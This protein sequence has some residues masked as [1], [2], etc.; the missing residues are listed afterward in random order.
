M[1]FWHWFIW[2]SKV[3]SWGT[4]VLWNPLYPKTD[5]LQKLSCRA[6]NENLFLSPNQKMLRFIYP[7]WSCLHVCSCITHYSYSFVNNSHSQNSQ[8]S[9]GSKIPTFWLVESK[10]GQTNFIV[11]MYLSLQI[12]VNL[13]DLVQKYL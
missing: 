2:Q 6:K 5:W 1:S 11:F 4:K 9:V 13:M 7:H 3:F 12:L 8:V 10:Q